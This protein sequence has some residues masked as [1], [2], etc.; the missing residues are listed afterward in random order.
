MEDRFQMS[1]YSEYFLDIIQKDACPILSSSY[2]VNALENNP[3]V[4]IPL[5]SKI[6]GGLLSKGLAVTLRD[7]Y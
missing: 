2:S 7:F 4:S 1:D 3:L 5:C 6:S